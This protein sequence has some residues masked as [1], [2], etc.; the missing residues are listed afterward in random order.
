MRILL[1]IVYL[2][3][4]VL[5]CSGDNPSS[6]PIRLEIEDAGIANAMKQVLERE[7]IW[8]E[9]IDKTTLAVKYSNAENAIQL[10]NSIS[11]GRLPKDR[12]ASF[13]KKMFVA[14]VKELDE[15]KVTYNIVDVAKSK[16]IVWE[17]KDVGKVEQLIDKVSRDQ[18][19]T[20]INEK[21]FK[22]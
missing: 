3:I 20:E 12:H 1:L 11:D 2:S 19:I 10:L 13:P 7:G 4:P 6:E 9:V 21:D 16:W 22:Y 18:N 14:L 8:Y 15:N 17:E 5:A